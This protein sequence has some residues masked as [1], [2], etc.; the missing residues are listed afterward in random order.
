MNIFEK[1]LMLVSVVVATEGIAQTNNMQV[2]APSS[3]DKIAPVTQPLAGTLFFGRDQRDKMDRV[4][5]LG[6]VAEV[7]DDD[8]VLV[9][10][11]VSVLNGFV[12]RSDGT[13]TVWVDGAYK[14]ISDSAVMARIQPA[15]VGMDTKSILVSGS[16][17]EGKAQAQTRAKVSVKKRKALR[18]RISGGTSSRK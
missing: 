15:S 2:T 1:S 9:E 17:V 12:K 4:R 3:V 16:A 5:K 13:A 8:G 10:P 14:S 18:K 6:T 7:K 11:A